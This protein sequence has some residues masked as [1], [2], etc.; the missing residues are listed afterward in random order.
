MGAAGDGAPGAVV[1]AAEIA[2]GAT[3]VPQVRAAK[4][5]PGGTLQP[6]LP[7]RHL[8]SRREEKHSLGGRSTLHFGPA[9]I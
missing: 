1:V 2:S 4:S 7:A 8:S 6:C 5:I 9:L 3:S